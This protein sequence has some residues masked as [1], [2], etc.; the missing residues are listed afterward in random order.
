MKTLL[1]DTVKW[2]LVL[3]VNGNIALAEEPYALAQDAASAIRT[4]FG[5]PWYNTT[6]GVNYDALLGH[7]PNIP[8]MK[9]EF[10]SEAL[11]TVP[12]IKQAKCFITSFVER[13]IQ[14]QVQTTDKNGNISAAAF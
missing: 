3:D 4:R 8:L 11:T 5:E 7:A 13:R 1:L 6:I 10:E 12:G 9:S 14:G 2:D